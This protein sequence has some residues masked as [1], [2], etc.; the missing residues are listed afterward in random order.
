MARNP[1]CKD[2]SLHQLTSHVNVPG[3]GNRDASVAVVIESPSPLCL[4]GKSPYKG[5]PGGLLKSLLQGAGI[6]PADV[7][8]THVIGCAV[9]PKTKIKGEHIRACRKY[10]EEELKEVNPEWTLLTG[11]TPIKFIKK[12]SIMEAHASPQEFE[13]RNYYPIISPSII[14]RDPTKQ[15][16]IENALAKFKELVDGTYVEPEEIEWYKVTKDNVDKFF[17]AAHDTSRFSFDIE[18]TGLL[19]QDPDFRVNCVSFTFDDDVSWVLPLYLNE[20]RK[21]AKASLTVVAKI[22]KQEGAKAIGHNCVTPETEVLT[23]GGWLPINQ[24]SK[25]EI[26]VWDPK[27]QEVKFEFP[28]RFIQQDFDGELCSWNHQMFSGEFTPDHRVY[29]SKSYSPNVY[30]VEPA[31]KVGEIGANNKLI[32][33]GGYY[34]GNCLLEFNEDELRLLEATRADGSILFS[35]SGRPSLRWKLKKQRKIDRLLSLLNSLEIPYSTTV[36]NSVYKIHTRVSEVAERLANFL[37]NHDKL[38]GPWVLNL[39]L[40]SREILLDEARYWDG[41]VSKSSKYGSYRFS[42]ANRQT[43]E[44]FQ[45]MAHLS[46]WRFTYKEKSNNRGYGE[47]KNLVLYGGTV[48]KKCHAKLQYNAEKTNYKGKVFCFEVST[49]AFLIRHRNRVSITGNCKFDN[50]GL[51]ARYGISFQVYWDTMLGSHTLNENSPHD[52]KYLA[53]V[54][55]GAP[56]YDDLSLAQKTGQDP[57]PQILHR[58][59]RYNAM[60]TYYTMQVYKYQKIKLRSSRDLSRLFRRLVI[61]IANRMEKIDYIGHEMDLEKIA[62]VRVELVAKIAQLTKELQGMG[63]TRKIINWGSPSQVADLLYSRMGI[64][65]QEF[66]PGGKPSTAESALIELKD[67]YPIVNKLLEW[68]GL[69]KQL[70][71]YIDGFQPLMVGSRL[72]ISTKLHGTVCFTADTLITTN[73]GPLPFSELKLGDLVLTHEGAWE[74]ITDKVENGVKPVFEVSTDNGLILKTTDN[75]PYL[76]PQGWVLAKDLIKG[77]KV[78]VYGDFEEWRGIPGWPEYKV[79]SWGRVRRLGKT[80]KARWKS[81]LRNRK[82]TL[83]RGDQS[84]KL[85]NRKDFTIHRLVAI[86]F[87]ENPNNYP[88]VRHLDGKAW[89]N[90]VKNLAWGTS[91]QNKQDK[92]LHGTSKKWDSNQAKLTWNQVEYIRERSSETPRPLDRELA[93]ELG[94]HRKLINLIR[95]GER[96][97]PQEV[98]FNPLSVFKTVKITQVKKLSSEETFG[99]EVKNH[100][101]HITNGIVTHNTGRFSSRLHQTPRD[102]TIRN[103]FTAPPGYV[104]FCADFSQIELRLV[105]H[106]SGDQRLIFIY[107]T[108]GDVHVTTA[109]EA[110]GVVRDPTK[111]ERK[112]AK[113]I[114]FGY[115]YGMGW[116]KFKKY[117]KEKYGVELTDQQAKAFRDRFFR[118]Y[119]GLSPWHDRVK[120]MVTENGFMRYLSGRYRRLPEVYSTDEGVRAEAIRQAINSPIQGFGSGDLKVMAMLAIME[121]FHPDP[122]RYMQLGDEV[123]ITGEVH[124][125][126]TGW[127]R[128]DKALENAKIIKELM[129]HPPLLPVFEIDLCVPLVAEIEIG[130]SWGNPDYTLEGSPITIKYH[131]N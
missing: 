83:Y 109:Q 1:N 105:A 35:G 40:K 86:S 12:T 74:P 32:P 94:V 87:I 54:Y 102:G 128:E 14:F 98:V 57:S 121:H 113:A 103:I 7:F 34:E 65:C 24:Y 79:S 123:I 22:L 122:D 85:G 119:S 47:G 5:G 64:P 11:A 104:F 59:Y 36:G 21:W 76:T 31:S 125:S 112:A 90:N 69:N 97:N 50:S 20:D 37:Y 26:A 6:D 116:K 72:Y 33:L 93:K 70:N 41:C 95:R 84:R 28:R 27:T 4:K 106:A 8:V 71:T 120:R 99:I 117:A 30:E 75:H 29:R 131:H 38:Y 23:P 25:T 126:I 100:H 118:L 91:K 127:L 48:T 78:I 9:P 13:G 73:R 101:S 10:L 81:D 107:Q 16:L 2:C 18:T 108:G 19:A 17:Q 61:P 68:R 45:V 110:M 80:C 53:K 55:C 129:E 44:W 62:Q 114:N 89:N 63:G 124:D 82:I 88:E 66:T 3:F 51:Y 56:E 96:W 111:E 92:V 49:G 42:T 115:V 60:D 130:K 39:D 52:L 77:Q 67:D 43:A 46:G 15:V 58:L